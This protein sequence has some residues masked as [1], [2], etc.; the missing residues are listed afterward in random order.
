MP[1]ENPTVADVVDLL[2]DMPPDAP[3][4]IGLSLPDIKLDVLNIDL[5]ALGCV[6]VSAVP[7]H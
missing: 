5:D 2:L 6:R 4:K 7:L 1:I 3:F